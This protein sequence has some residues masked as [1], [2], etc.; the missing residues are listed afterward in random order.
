MRCMF[1]ADADGNLRCSKHS[2]N[3]KKILAYMDYN[4]L[5]TQRG[6]I[7][8]HCLSGTPDSDSCYEV[9]WYEKIEKLLIRNNFTIILRR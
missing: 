8:Y 4:W 9:K 7:E 3:L 2:P 6:I 1:E 5:I